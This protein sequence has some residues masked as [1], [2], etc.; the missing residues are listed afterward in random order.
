[1]TGG[2]DVVS[3]AY[4]RDRDLPAGIASVKYKDDGYTKDAFVLDCVYFEFDGNQFGPINRSFIIRK[5]EGEK[6]ITS[7][8]VYP[9]N[10]DPRSDQLRKEILERG[11]R[12][13]HLSNP[14]HTAHRQ[15]QGLT[16]DHQP[17]QVRHRCQRK[18]I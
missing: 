14:S 7:L 1:M 5:F 11:R 8:P 3:R 13:A 2:R 9:L 15:Y 18:L 6:P 4:V 12:Y 17:E 16:L 10:L